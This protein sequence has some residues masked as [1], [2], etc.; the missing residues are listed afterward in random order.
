MEINPA[1]VLYSGGADSTM[2]AA[3]M[4]KN[5]SPVH[6]LTFKHC[7]MSQLNKT[8]DSAEN[9]FEHF[10]KSSVIHHWKDITSLWRTIK[11]N[12]PYTAMTLKGGFALLLKPCLACKAAM[13]VSTLSYCLENGIS[14]AADGAHPKGA[15]LFPEQTNEGIELI[16][17][18]Y[19]RYG[20]AYETPVYSIGR[21][22]FK[23]FDMGITRKKNTGDEHIYYSNQFACH[24]G[25][26]AY[27]YHYL[28]R[29][30][31]KEKKRTFG[32]CIDFLNECLSEESVAKMLNLK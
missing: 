3:V 9:L 26:L 20:I 5:H 31:D 25:L 23:L 8:T 30:L 28:S 1:C 4:L 22:D 15:P 16:R 12:P 2:A 18:F 10:G 11:K 13:H 24:V 6:L 27:V 19:N 32:L 7:R 21:P 17:S 14:I 29:P